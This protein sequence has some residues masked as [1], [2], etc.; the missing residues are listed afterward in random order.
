MSA[1]PLSDI[2]VSDDLRS[3]DQSPPGILSSYHLA[4]L[5]GKVDLCQAV[6]LQPISWIS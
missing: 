3:G 5:L 4:N 6:E 1:P 2:H